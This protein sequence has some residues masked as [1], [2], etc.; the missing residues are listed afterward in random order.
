MKILGEQ[1][2]IQRERD[3]IRSTY[4]LSKDNAPFTCLSLTSIRVMCG[5]IQE[6]HVH[7]SSDQIWLALAGE[8]SL[9][10]DDGSIVALTAGQIVYFQAGDVHGVSNSTSNDFSYLSITVPRQGFEQA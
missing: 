2:F 4:L 3:G 7:H 5:G 10:I 9:L 8:A 6:R 1:D